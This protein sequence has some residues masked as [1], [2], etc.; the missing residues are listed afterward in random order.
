MF[1]RAR[2]LRHFSRSPLAVSSAAILLVFLVAAVCAPLFAPHDPYDLTSLQLTDRLKP[3]M[4]MPGGSDSF[5]LGTDDQGRGILSAILYGMR[6]S[7]LIGA[8]AVFLAF[9]VGAALGLVAGFFGGRLDALI[10][11]VADV[12]LSFPAFLLALLLLGIARQRGAIPVI[13]AIAATFWVRY[14]RVMRGNVLRESKKEYIEAAKVMGASHMRIIFR[15]LLPNSV[16][17]LFVVAA[18]D[19]GMVIVLEAT[20]SFLGVGLPL[21]SPSLGMLIASGYQYLYAS[22]WWP[23]FFPALVLA[24]LVLAINLLGDWLR[25]ELNPRMY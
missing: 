19:L 15:H 3:P 21:T 12:M 8:G 10:G 2:F 22:I 16:A 25:R 7:F 20:L 13:L 5:P 18:V 4:W 14:C 6:A 24:I 23:V 11:R 1:D 17:T 9:C